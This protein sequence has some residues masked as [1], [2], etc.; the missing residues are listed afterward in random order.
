MQD[1]RN[2][3]VWEKS[4]L[5]ALEVYKQ[6]KN[7]PK[8][9]LYGIVSQ[10]RRAATSIPTNIAEGC[11]RFSYKETAQFMQIAFASANELEY[12]LLLSKDLGLL[13]ETDYNIYVTNLEEVKKML[14]A[15][16]K[17]IKTDK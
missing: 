16:I 7:Y 9:E 10:I 13:P 14:S 15:L 3:K 8:E 1:F 5:L 2:L 11:G 6:T 17:K 4:H 12:L